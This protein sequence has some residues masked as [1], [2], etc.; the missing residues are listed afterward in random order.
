MQV[1]ANGIR[2]NVEVRGEGPWLV[3]SHSLACSTR[4]WDEQVAALSGRFRVVNVDTRGHGA[5]DAPEGP[6]TLEQLSDDLQAVL[7]ALGVERCHYMGLSMGGMIGMTHALRHPGRLQSLALCNT[8]SRLGPSVLPVWQQRIDSVRS[9]GMG[10][11]VDGTLERWF[12]ASTRAARPDLVER[13]GAMI[14]ST[15]VAGYVGCCGAIPHI[16]LT[17]QLG[18]VQV[19]TLVVVGDQDPGTPLEMSRAI[20]NAIPKAQLAVIPGAAHLSNM[21]QPEV[22]NFLVERWLAALTRAH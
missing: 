13:V 16:D 4:M 11:L 20:Q 9:R 10:A 12:T 14:R 19:P 18:A 17:D 6:Y 7:D 21:E 3:L 5:S 2:I 1:Q 22:F 8:S 15:P